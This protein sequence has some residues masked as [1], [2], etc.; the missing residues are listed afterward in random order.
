MGPPLFLLLSILDITYG[1][2]GFQDRIPNGNNVLNPCDRSVWSGVGHQN[3]DGGGHRNPFGLAFARNGL[4]WTQAL[5]QDD[6]DGDGH[7]NGVELGDPNCVWMEGRAPEQPPSGHPGICEIWSADN[8]VRHNGNWFQCNPVGLRCPAIRGQGVQQ[9]QFRMPQTPI[10]TAESTTMCVNLALPADRDYHVIADTAVLDNQNVVHHMVLYACSVG[11]VAQLQNPVGQ[12]YTCDMLPEPQCEEIITGWQHGVAGFCHPN[13]VGFSVGATS[14]RYLA[15][16]I[17]WVNP[18]R[19]SGLV[20]TSGIALFLTPNLRQ[21]NLSTLRIG[22]VSFS[23]P[24][25]A[26]SFAVHGEC[27]S[28]CTGRHLTGPIHV[29][30]SFDHMNQAGREIQVTLKRRGLDPEVTLWNNRF[31]SPQNPVFHKFSNLMIRPGDSVHTYCLYNT[32]SRNKTTNFGYRAGDETCF[33]FLQYYPAENSITKSCSS[34]GGIPTCQLSD[35]NAV[36]E[37][38]SA[39]FAT[40]QDMAVIK[41]FLSDNCHPLRCL[42]ECVNVVK[43]IRRHACF[44]KE[45]LR[46]HVEESLIQMKMFELLTQLHSCDVEIAKEE[47][48]CPGIQASPQIKSTRCL[49]NKR[50]FLRWV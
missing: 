6:S 45:H 40:S 7:S 26:N 44:Q 32:E 14:A 12:P 28:V 48:T 24:P 34:S 37:G 5:C 8:C 41:Q 35:P 43:A 20:D 4:R 29:Y 22:D 13:H 36:I 17:H 16:Q 21:Y 42:V 46:K 27:A 31:F 15:L 23:I 49:C 18:S 38:C 10:P 19:R 39:S 1:F 30:Q 2:R 9:R 25:K 47:A 11:N 50:P 33:T 3:K